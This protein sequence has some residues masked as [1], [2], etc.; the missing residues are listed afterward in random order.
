MSELIYQ[1]LKIVISLLFKIFYRLKVEGLENLPQEGR[2][3]LASNHSSY[4][5]P[6]A[7]G[8]AALP[9]RINFMVLRVYYD[10]WPARWFFKA[11]SSF[12]VDESKPDVGAFRHALKVLRRG[13]ILGIFPEGGRSKDGRLKEGKLGA[14]LLASKAGVPILPAAVI[15]AFEAFPPGALF[16]KLG[17]I[18]V[19]FGPPITLGN[20]S[21]KRV[22]G[23]RLKLVTKRMMSAIGKLMEEV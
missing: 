17:S 9:R 19:R 12:P 22:D 7:I 1:S 11:A 21:D 23:E 2:F 15:G 5:D 6:L 8:V 13:G 10:P 16:P 3:I 4:F 18:R 20:Y 14:A